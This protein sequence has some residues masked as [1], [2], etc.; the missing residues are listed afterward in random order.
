MRNISAI[1]ALKALPIHKVLP[2]PFA[3]IWQENLLALNYFEINFKLI[4]SG[5]SP[6]PG[7]K[8]FTWIKIT[9]EYLKKE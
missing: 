4:Q 8:N 7:R 5:F 3:L 2:A 9:I 6:P 1:S